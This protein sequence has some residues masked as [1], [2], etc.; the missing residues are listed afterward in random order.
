[1]ENKKFLVITVFLG[2]MFFCVSS[3]AMENNNHEKKLENLDGNKKE[4][5]SENED[6]EE[7]VI[8]IRDKENLLK[9]MFDRNFRRIGNEIESDE[10]K[11]YSQTQKVTVKYIQKSQTEPDNGYEIPESFTFGGKQLGGYWISKYELSN[12]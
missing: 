2:V 10:Y 11:L 5:N 8:K 4:N 6:I 12:K 3:G 1:M 9:D 7:S